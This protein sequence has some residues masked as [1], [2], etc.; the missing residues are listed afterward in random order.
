VSNDTQSLSSD[1]QSFR[2]IRPWRWAG[3]TWRVL[4]L[5]VVALVAIAVLV[6]ALS[7]V[8]LLPKFRNPFAETTVNR[9]QPAVLKS[10]TALSRFEAA[11]GSFQV[12]VDLAKKSVFL[13]S[14]VEG[15][16]TLFV[17]AGTDIAYV[18]FSHLNSSSVTVS[19]TRT[20][21][22]IRL[23]AARLEP[24]VLNVRRSYVFAQ[25]Q[26]LLNRIGNFFSGNPDSQHQVYVVA[27]Q[28]IQAAAQHST[29]IA[30][31]EVNTR[32]MLNGFMKSLGFKRVTVIFTPSTA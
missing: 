30:Q 10:I 32:K 26:G 15:S 28:K 1:T 3:A 19:G 27:Q 21:V 4:R 14:F 16:D 12:I 20:A 18:D 17:G 29:L 23:P 31:A 9:S 13:P 25:Q 11:S 8:H 6:V 5:A 7:A 24:A 22:T 2:R